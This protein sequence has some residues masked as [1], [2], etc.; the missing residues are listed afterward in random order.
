MRGLEKGMPLW[1]TLFR[2]KRTACADAMAVNAEVVKLVYTPALGAGAFGRV[3]SSPTF[4]T[5]QSVLLCR[6]SISHLA[7]RGFDFS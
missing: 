4:G 7:L 2:Y 3:G 5:L 6:A 1:Y